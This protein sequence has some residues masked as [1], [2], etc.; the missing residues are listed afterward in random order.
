MIQMK[1]KDYKELIKFLSN[2]KNNICACGYECNNNIA[3]YNYNEDE[4]CLG[5]W[6]KTLNQIIEP[7]DTEHKLH[8]QFKE[9]IPA[10]IQELIDEEI[11]IVDEN[12]MNLFKHVLGGIYET[13]KDNYKAEAN[14]AIKT[15]LMK[16]IK[17]F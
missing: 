3:A 11:I 9:D 8:I 17:D 6:R 16:I 12:K 2:E 14:E 10:L 4:A 13:A 5:C 1:E 15:K 7:I